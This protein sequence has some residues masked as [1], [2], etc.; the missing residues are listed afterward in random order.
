MNKAI[1]TEEF[2]F[3]LR[4]DVVDDTITQELERL[5]LRAQGVCEDFCRVTFDE[6]APE[7]VKLAVTLLASHYHAYREGS[8]ATAERTIR[9][10]AE[11]LLWPHRD[12]DKMF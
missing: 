3:Y 7:A 10:A 2:A 4:I 5:I 1:T 9:T 8:D 11:N 6:T 12:P